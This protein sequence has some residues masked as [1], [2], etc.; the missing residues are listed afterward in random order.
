MD[1]IENLSSAFGIFQLTSVDFIAAVAGEEFGDEVGTVEALERFDDVGTIG[2]IIPEEVF[3][4]GEFFF[5]GGGGENF[6]AGVGVDSGV[7]N[8]GREGHWRRGEVLN[9]FEM[10]VEVAGL[11][12]E[13]G[14]VDFAASGMT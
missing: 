2:G 11:D 1:K 9:L 10:E 13:Q 8:L 7:E 5:G 14:H 4:L 6:L 12:G 3:A